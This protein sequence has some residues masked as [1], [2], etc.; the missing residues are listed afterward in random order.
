VAATR[1]SLA[2]LPLVLF[3]QYGSTGGT[4]TYFRQLLGFYERVGVELTVIR[5]GPPGDTDMD[6]FLAD[7]GVTSLDWASIRPSASPSHFGLYRRQ[8]LRQEIEAEAAVVRDVASSVGAS[9]V[10]ASVGDPGSHLG[11]MAAASRGLYFLHTYPHGI[12]SAVNSR[13][14]MPGSFPSSARVVTVS[15]FAAKRIV[16]NWRLS[17]RAGDVRYVYSSTGPVPDRGAT[18]RDNATVLTVGHVEH[19]KDPL[20]WIDIAASVLARGAPMSQELKFIWVGDGSL[21][22]SCRR[23]LRARRLEGRVDFVGAHHDLRTLY[24]EAAVYL[25]PSRVE[26]LG[27]GVLDA[28]KFGVPAVVTRVGGLP[29]VV[30]SGTSGIVYEPGHNQRAARAVADLLSRPDERAAL[31]FEARRLYE[32]R[33]G[34]EQWESAIHAIHD[35]II[36]APRRGP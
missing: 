33:F 34:P 9:L 26:S 35:E 25:Q 2:G 36:Q 3:A 1:K 16:R 8:A 4:R 31:G 23:T 13:L 21:L 12:R 27:L 6:D 24:E 22:D 11:A 7:R 28:A 32:E 15:A 5:Q 18:V 14:L 10:V 29:E 30:E 20:G 17:S 19:Y